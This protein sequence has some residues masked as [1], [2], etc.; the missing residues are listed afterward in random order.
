MK[1]AVAPV[2]FPEALPGSRAGWAAR[3]RQAALRE[4]A[5]QGAEGCPVGSVPAVVPWAEACREVVDHPEGADSVGSALAVACR[6]VGHPVVAQA[7]VACPVGS[8]LAVE[9]RA[10]VHPVAAACP[11][12]ADHPEA[13]D[14]AGSALAVGH[15][16]VAQAA[17][18]YPVGSAPVAVRP[19]AAACPVAAHAPEDCP[20]LVHRYAQA[21]PQKRAA[22]S[23]PVLP[24]ERLAARARV[25]VASAAA[26]AHRVG[27]A[28]PAAHS[29]GAQRVLDP[30]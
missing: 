28:V 26:V 19:V 4:A 1:R 23:E 7:A 12:A 21:D 29:P 5:L 17:V 22:R 9:H 2:A 3:V 11:V 27:A 15:P 13:V 8:A 16:V 18:A 14:S 30:R 10:A 6:A 25:G 20:A 24:A